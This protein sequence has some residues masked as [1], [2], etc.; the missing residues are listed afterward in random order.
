VSV[1]HVVPQNQVVRSIF[2][3]YFRCHMGMDRYVPDSHSLSLD[4]YSRCSP[5]GKKGRAF[6]QPLAPTTKFWWASRE[7]NTAPTDYESAALTKH[8]L[9]AQFFAQTLVCKFTPIARLGDEKFQPQ[10]VNYLIGVLH[11]FRYR[12]GAPPN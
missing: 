11:E 2:C 9:E 8:E 3:I 5:D 7:S 4:G 6:T 10:I 12:I 1:V